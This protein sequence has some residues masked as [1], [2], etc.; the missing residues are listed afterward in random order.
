[1]PEVSANIDD[2]PEE[3]VDLFN[4]AKSGSVPV[5]QFFQAFEEHDI[6]SVRLWLYA[7]KAYNLPLEKLKEIDHARG[8]GLSD[9]DV[10]ELCEVIDE[11]NE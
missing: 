7:H 3:L 1:M 6:R 11:L 5:S 9:S 8:R 10:D 4:K 2:L